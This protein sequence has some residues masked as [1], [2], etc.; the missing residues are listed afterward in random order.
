MVTMT[1]NITPCIWLDDTAEAAADLY[2]SLFP[3]SKRTSTVHYPTDPEALGPNADKAGQVLIEQVELDG[4]SFTLLN[5]GPQFPQ[6]EAVSF[7]IMCDDQAEVDHYWDGFTANGG[8]EGQCGWCKDPFGVSWQVIP[9]RFTELMGDP[10]PQIVTRV[11]QAMFGM[12]K[13]DVEGLER[14]ARGA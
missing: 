12:R 8:S 14:A 5:G 1:T 2:L 9:R 10:D 7:Q 4:K 11:S 6:T 3:N 13:L